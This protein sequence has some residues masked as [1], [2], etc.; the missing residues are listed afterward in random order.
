ME[1]LVSLPYF[2]DNVQSSCSNDTCKASVSSLFMKNTTS[3]EESST[4]RENACNNLIMCIITTLNKG[5][6]S[7]G[8]IGDVLRSPSRKV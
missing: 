1:T 6:R 4:V 8:G 2:L 7:G 5:V 3:D